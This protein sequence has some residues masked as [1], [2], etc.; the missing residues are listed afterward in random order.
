[1]S[2]NVVVDCNVAVVANGRGT[3][4]SRDCQLACISELERI[5]VA[6]RVALDKGGLVLQGYRGHLSFSGQPGT[7]DMFFKHLFYNQYDPGRVSRVKITPSDSNRGFEELPPNSLDP[8]D[9]KF[10]AVAVVAQA[11]ILNAT[12]SDWSEHAHL[13]DNLGVMVDQLCPEYAVMT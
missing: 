11:P 4:A 2:K 9:R 10:L 7:G 12:D 3:H 8:A 5:V 13:L 1:M 6:H